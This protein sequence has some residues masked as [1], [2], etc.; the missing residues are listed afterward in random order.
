MAGSDLRGSSLYLQRKKIRPGM[1]QELPESSLRHFCRT[2]LRDT[3]QRFTSFAGT[4]VR[5]RAF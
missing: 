5:R 2:S 3:F 1:I 4:G